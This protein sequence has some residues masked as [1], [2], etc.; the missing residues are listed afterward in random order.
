MIASS[1]INLVFVTITQQTSTN[2]TITEK[3]RK[4]LDKGKFAWGVFLDFRKAF[5]TVNYEI[6]QAKLQRYGVREVPFNWFKS[7]LEDHIQ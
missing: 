3:I 2:I 5:D 1:H 7:Y 6:L 4:N